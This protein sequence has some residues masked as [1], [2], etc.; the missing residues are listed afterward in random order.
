M[1]K[2]DHKPIKSINVNGIEIDIVTYKLLDKYW[3]FIWDYNNLEDLKRV[4]R[5]ESE[6]RYNKNLKEAKK[7]VNSKKEYLNILNKEYN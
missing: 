7:Q 2:K 1:R 6:R 4:V 3:I 5:E